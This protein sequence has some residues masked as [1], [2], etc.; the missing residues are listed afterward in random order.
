M[1][2]TVIMKNIF[3]TYAIL[4]SFTCPAQM[5]WKDSSLEFSQIEWNNY[6]T[7]YI[8][9]GKDS[10]PLL[11]MA[12]AYN[13][14]Y[15]IDDESKRSAMDMSFNSSAYRFRSNL[16][17][18]L[19]INTY[20]SAAAYFLVPG[21]YKT[22]AAEYEYR[23]LKNDK[24]TKPWSAIDRFT[25]P[26]FQLNEFKKNFAFLGG[27]AGIW[28]DCVIVEIR[29]KATGK[30]IAAAIVCWKQTRPRLFSI[31]STKEFNK[32]VLELKKPFDIGD[33]AEA[34]K[35]KKE[36]PADQLDSVT[37]LPKKLV[38]PPGNDGVV[39]FINAYIYKKEALE[40]RLTKNKTI[41][42][43][44]G[45]NDADNNFIWLQNL[46]PG[47]Y[48]IDIRYQKQRHNVTSYPFELKPAWYQALWFKVLAFVFGVVFIGFI[49]L[50]FA[51]RI[52]KRKMQREVRKR[53]KLA[54]SLQSV[55]AQLNP[56]FI[57]NSLSSIQGLINKNDIAAANLY[58]SDF[59]NL[60]RHSLDTGGKT[61]IPLETEL[62]NLATYLKLEQMRFGFFYEMVTDAAI[63]T[64]AVEIPPMLLQPL[65]ENAIKH[66][67]SGLQEKGKIGI[68]ISRSQN[69]MTISISDNGAGF[70]SS[71][72]TTGYGL[73]LTRNRISLLNDMTGEEGITLQID[74]SDNGTQARLLFKN[75]LA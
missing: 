20:D 52:Q 53:E 13:G 28:G 36:Y 10:V 21:I 55:D 41:I 6:S 39:F 44:W 54:L 70:D 74:S 72:S 22:N 23:V 43:D 47:D 40:Y 4:L 12:T 75:A 49:F 33:V 59:G 37:G 30:V 3:F 14:V 32:K 45:P 69:D 34:K 1:A 15:D 68:H 9:K 66:G 42:R 50:V 5:N 73:N 18:V 62:S 29:K 17:K 26:S 58:L 7:S 2:K 57:F 67:V 25:D 63:D 56:H 19:S 8:G 31:L 61:S 16:S 64:G 46:T 60:V 71:K 51:A 48:V 24:E 38:L 27:Y 35:W 11:V 65:V